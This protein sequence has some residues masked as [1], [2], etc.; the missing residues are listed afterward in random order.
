MMGLPTIILGVGRV[1]LAVKP[2]A[3]IDRPLNGLNASA[4]LPRNSSG[5]SAWPRPILIKKNKELADLQLV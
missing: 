5:P 4:S 1:R 3:G 2:P